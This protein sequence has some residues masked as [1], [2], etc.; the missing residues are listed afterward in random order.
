MSVLGWP[1]RRCF[2]ESALRVRSFTWAAA[3]ARLD[4]GVRDCVGT[5]RD[6]SRR[7]RGQPPERGRA[8]WRS[9]CRIRLLV[10]SIL[11]P[12]RWDRRQRS[13]RAKRSRWTKGR[14]H[15]K[16]TARVI[17]R[18][19]GSR[20]RVV[21][22]LR[23][24]GCRRALGCPGDRGNRHHREREHMQA[25]GRISRTVTEV[26]REPSARRGSAQNA[27][28]AAN[29]VSRWKGPVRSRRL[30]GGSDPLRSSDRR[31]T[32]QAVHLGET[33]ESRLRSV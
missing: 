32:A 15:E 33:P 20:S 14:R 18:L 9:G 13:P 23:E 16:T 21:P 10:C 26:R 17:C 4:D 19:Y 1:T 6:R 28:A 30:A 24:G 27:N 2:P 29:G 11:R 5:K 8:P 22:E 7:G 12:R 3:E 25:L 31:P